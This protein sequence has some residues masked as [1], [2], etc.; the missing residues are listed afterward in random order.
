M[1][2]A[3]HVPQVIVA[4]AVILLMLLATAMT[5]QWEWLLGAAGGVVLVPVIVG[6]V[7]KSKLEREQSRRREFASFSAGDPVVEE[8]IALACSKALSVGFVR[9]DG[10]LVGGIPPLGAER[11]LDLAVARGDL[12]R[13][14]DG[15]YRPSAALRRKREEKK[16]QVR[17]AQRR[18]K[19]YADEKAAKEAAA[20]AEREARKASAREE[21]RRRRS[22]RESEAREGAE[23]KR[24]GRKKRSGDGSRRGDSQSFPSGPLGDAL[25]VL[26]VDANAGRDE[27]ERSWKDH[28][29]RNHPDLGGSTRISQQINAAWET[30]RR[31]KGWN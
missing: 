3:Y 10:I 22:E 23:A 11:M 8:F 29:R 15:S 4:Y 30:V 9:P 16:E 24:D 31:H 5:G 25:A 20:R 12:E 28:L 17:E 6:G 27:V 13:G 2:L 26:N 7:A 21:R 14:V 1:L 18:A 19:A